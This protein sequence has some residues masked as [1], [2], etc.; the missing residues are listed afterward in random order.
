[1]FDLII[2]G[3]G[4]AAAA[5]AVYAARKR[6]KTLLVTEE[7]G[8]QS[9]VSADVQN[10]IG[11]PSIS[12]A[13]LAKN[14]RTHVETYKGDSVEILF[15]MRAT[16]LIPSEDK[17]TI[18]LKDGKK[19]EAKSALIASGARRRTLD[20][21]GAK[22]YD[23]KGLTYC[24]SCDGPLFADKDVAVIGGGNA[25]FETALQLLAYCKTVTLVNRTE[26]FR[27]DE[28]TVAAVRAYPNMRIVTNAELLEVVG[29]AQTPSGDSVGT[30]ALPGGAKFVTG[31]K[32]KD[33]KTGKESVLPVEGIFVE[34]GLLPNTEW[35]GNALEKTAVGQIKVDPRTHRTSHPRV[36]AAGDVTDGVYHQNN[37][38][39]GDAVKALEDIY[40]SL[41]RA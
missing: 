7:W 35:I 40:V 9:N 30:R 31:L 37:I 14:L 13:E 15:P 6:L 27:A 19:V 26:T 1:M 22:E 38:A 11:T 25:A 39:A 12:G 3:G 16:A 4:P 20:V 18:E 2:I 21:P 29:A 32:L 36:W 28:T 23:Q 17:V 8:G 5:A 10:W 24:A 33:T 41:R 34:I